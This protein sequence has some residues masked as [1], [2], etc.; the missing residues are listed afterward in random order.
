MIEQSQTEKLAMV[1]QPMGSD[2]NRTREELAGTAVSMQTRPRGRR[3]KVQR[4][5]QIDPTTCERDY[6]KDEI[7]FM[8]A[9]DKYK[10]ESGRPFPTCGE[11]LDVLHSLGYRRDEGSLKF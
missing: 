4:R 7:E 11:V 10:R 5:R 8:T 6:Q 9:M 3:P 2:S 1:D